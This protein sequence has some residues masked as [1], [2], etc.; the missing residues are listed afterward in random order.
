MNIWVKPCQLIC[1]TFFGGL[2]NIISGPEVLEY[3]RN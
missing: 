1:L 3:L 2:T